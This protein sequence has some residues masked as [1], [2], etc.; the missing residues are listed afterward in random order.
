MNKLTLSIEQEII[1]AAKAYAR[2]HK[3]S[4]SKLVSRFLMELGNGPQDDFFE[5]LHEELRREGFKAPKE[6]LTD[7]RQHHVTRKYL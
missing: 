2:L 3:M 6:N 7:L 1:D 4:L 5:K